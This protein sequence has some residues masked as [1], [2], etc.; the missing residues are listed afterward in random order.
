MQSC[1]VGTTF[2]HYYL[3]TSKYM[4][5]TLAIRNESV[6]PQQNDFPGR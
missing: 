5:K 2:A 6:K 1:C 4:R 3:I